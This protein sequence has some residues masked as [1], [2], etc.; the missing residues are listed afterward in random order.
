MPEQVQNILTRMGEWWKKFNIRQKALM[1]SLTAIV[2]LSLGILAV[3]VTRPTY[4]PL[5]DCENAKM[6]NEVKQLLD[7]N[8]SIK[9]KVTDTI[10]FE[11]EASDENDANMLLGSNNISTMGYD[12]TKADIS[13]VVDG[14]FSTTEAD[15]QKLYKQ[16]LETKM[17]E[18]LA[19]SVLVE[20]ATVSLDIPVDDG[21]LIS[22]MQDSSASVSLALTGEMDE[23]Q[24]YAIARFVAT[25]LG[26]DSL[27][28][29]TLINQKNAKILFSGADMESDSMIATNNL[30]TQRKASADVEKR[31]KDMLVD[32]GMYSDVQVGLNLD[33][34]FDKS[35]ITEHDFSHPEGQDNGELV[36]SHDAESSSTGGQ[37]AVPGTDSNDENTY[38]T[39]D[40]EV[41][42][43]STSEQDR[44]YNPNEK[45]TKTT[46]SGGKINYDTGTVAVAAT[47]FVIYDEAQLK[48]SGELDDMSFDEFKAAHSDPLRVDVT[49][50]EI[51]MVAK[52]AGFQAANVSFVCYERPQ[53]VEAERK[54]IGVTDILQIVLAVLIFAL[55]GY[56]VF[57]STRKQK[58]EEP[59]PEIS[60]D[61]LLEATA[62]VATDSLEDIGYAEKSETRLLIEKFVDENPDAVA[63]LL[64][65]WLNEDWE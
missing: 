56:V 22:R 57:R 62:D 9:Y 58:E 31:I 47:R 43:S 26:N 21:T 7:D 6:A 49:Q 23:E 36:R 30:S 54:N 35:E 16:Y 8:G 34:S 2:L 27:K 48:A 40:G 60:V 39:Q 45:I 41:S 63:L 11:V 20:S 10:H 1:L 50:E 61:A 33:M 51:D 42:S 32:S 12:L 28:N 18:D 17:A 14:S 25:A 3:V 19:S 65:N 5:I 53:F 44:W 13:K 59:E 37:A 46:N 24:A 55:L 52:A 29:I 4:V 38:L 64:R 15:K